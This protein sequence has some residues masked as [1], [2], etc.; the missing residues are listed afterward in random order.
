MEDVGGISGLNSF[1]GDMMKVDSDAKQ[2]E[3]FKQSRH[4]KV[5]SRTEGRF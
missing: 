2:I 4:N 1:E 3:E 5:L